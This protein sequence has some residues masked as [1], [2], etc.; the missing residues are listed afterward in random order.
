MIPSSP[1]VTILRAT[2]SVVRKRA[3]AGQRLEGDVGGLLDLRRV[4]HEV[5]GGIDTRQVGGRQRPGT[6]R[7]G[8]EPRADGASF[9]PLSGA[10]EMQRP[11]GADETLERLD[12]REH[13]LP[14]IDPA[15]EEDHHPPGRNAERRFEP[16]PIAMRRRKERA[17]DPPSE[18]PHPSGRQRARERLDLL[19]AGDQR[20]GAEPLVLQEPPPHAR[21]GSLGQAE[22]IVEEASEPGRSEQPLDGRCGEEARVA[23]RVR[24]D[25]A[26][27]RHFSA[28]GDPLGRPGIGEVGVGRVEE[29]GVGEVAGE[30]RVMGSEV[31]VVRHVG[32]K[33]QA[34]RAERRSMEPEAD[35]V[36][37]RAQSRA[38]RPAKW[39]V[40]SS[41]AMPTAAAASFSQALTCPPASGR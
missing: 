37:E 8:P 11:A 15:D 28:A 33:G 26:G 25:R 22:T 31:G 7:R 38:R 5:R 32:E 3:A 18:E 16:G 23:R 39:T 17:I 30:V 27:E 24:V 29:V 35:V 4:G 6:A 14:A 9:G 10:E 12:Q 1:S 36:G 21:L 20:G 41:P 13:V 40:R 19:G 2:V 34:R